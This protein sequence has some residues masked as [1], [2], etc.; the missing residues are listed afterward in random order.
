M[1]WN[2]DSGP[3]FF[4]FLKYMGAGDHKDIGA[5]YGELRAERPLP[6]P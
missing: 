6:H 2:Q 1:G 3:S 4:G 5:G